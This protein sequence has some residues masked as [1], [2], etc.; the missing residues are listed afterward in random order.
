M[1]TCSECGG[2]LEIGDWPFC[3]GDPSN[4][5]QMTHFGEEPL[6]PYM[7][8]HLGPEPIEIRTRGERRRIMSRNHLDYLDVSDKR[9]GARIYVDLGR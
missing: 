8:E 3:N 5:V 4:H 1:S 9:R 6:T 2:Q 7:D